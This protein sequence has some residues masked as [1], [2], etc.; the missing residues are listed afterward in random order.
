M[1]LPIFP[2][3]GAVLFPNTSLPLNIFENRYI[4]MVD[5]ALSKNR[6][7]GMIQTDSNK[8]LY[9]VGCVGKIQSFS[10]T[11][12]GR[13]LITLIGTNC[14]K[15]VEENEMVYDFRIVKAKILENS[16]KENKFTYDQK[17]A[18]LQ[19]YKKYA[20]INKIDLDLL[21]F[22][23]IEVEQIIK[24]IAMISP[25]KDIEKQALLE[26]LNLNEFYQKLQS[27]IELETVSESLNK[28]IN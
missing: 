19:K 25:F 22:E 4:D 13:Y 17:T 23:K 28:T 12:D 20:D 24:F 7:I 26:T 9:G 16:N 5:F 21:E 27:I 15:V 2:L 11:A 14:F 6:L 8:K 18:L 3:N 10:E 1:D